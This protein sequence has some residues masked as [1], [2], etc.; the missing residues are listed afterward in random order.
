M[1]KVGLIVG[2]A[3]VALVTSCAPTTIYPKVVGGSKS[4]ATVTL[5]GNY[6]GGPGN[7]VVKWDAAKADAVR[8]CQAWG[9]RDADFFPEASQECVRMGATCIEWRVSWQAQCV[10]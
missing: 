2:V 8:R 7:Y 10:E 5:A 4:D 6:T 9:Y 3:F 1:K